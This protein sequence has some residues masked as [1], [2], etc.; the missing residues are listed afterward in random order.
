MQTNKVSNKLCMSRETEN[1]KISD[2]KIFTG[3]IKIRDVSWD[4]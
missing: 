1:T 4:T 3:P 2:N